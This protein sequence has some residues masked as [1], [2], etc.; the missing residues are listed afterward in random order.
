[1][2]THGSD[3]VPRHMARLHLEMGLHGHQVV[4]D[5]AGDIGRHGVRRKLEGWKTFLVGQP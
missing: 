5:V 3:E 1:M 4:S 2:P